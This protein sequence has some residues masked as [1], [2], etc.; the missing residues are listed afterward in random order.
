MPNLPQ[1]VSD[2]KAKWSVAG[3]VKRRWFVAAVAFAAG[4]IVRSFL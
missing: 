2:A 4:F 3:T 1:I